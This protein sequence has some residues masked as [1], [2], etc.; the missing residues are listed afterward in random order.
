MA[1]PERWD[2]EVNVM[3]EAGENI[4]VMDLRLL[5]EVLARLGQ[6]VSE[7][8]RF[9][10]SR[11]GLPDEQAAVDAPEGNFYADGWMLRFAEGDLPICEPYGVGVLFEGLRPVRLEDLREADSIED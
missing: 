3:V 8:S 7:A 4:G 9:V 10:G 1:E 11:L 5:G 6:V 2:V